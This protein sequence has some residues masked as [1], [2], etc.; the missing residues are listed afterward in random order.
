MKL[1]GRVNDVS[2]AY[3][4]KFSN[5]ELCHIGVFSHRNNNTYATVFEAI[6]TKV[7]N[8]ALSLNE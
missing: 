4:S 2:A 3:R 1:I 7:G 8:R 5:Y 6:E